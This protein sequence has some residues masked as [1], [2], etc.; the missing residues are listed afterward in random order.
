MNVKT[1]QKE[2]HQIANEHGWWE[3]RQESRIPEKLCLIH[4]EI[5][6]ALEAYRSYVGDGPFSLVAN[7]VHLHPDEHG[8]IKPE[9][10][11]VELADALIRILDLCEAFQI[12]MEEALRWKIAYNKARPYKHGKRV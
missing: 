1:L 12:D 9:G 6:E 8:N 7:R 4:S 2:V 10:F 5:S 3:S 11:G